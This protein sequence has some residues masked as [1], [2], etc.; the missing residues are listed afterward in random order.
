MAAAEP[1]GTV[2]LSTAKRVFSP[3]SRSRTERPAGR[4]V[5]VKAL[6]SLA[7]VPVTVAIVASANGSP[8]TTETCACEMAIST[9]VDGGA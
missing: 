5:T 8:C 4:P 9:S 7:S 6:R 2:P 3:A 1:R